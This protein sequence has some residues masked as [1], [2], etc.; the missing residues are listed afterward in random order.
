M[1]KWLALACMCLALPATAQTTLDLDQA[2][3]RALNHDPRIDEKRHYVAA[4]RGLLEEV[5]GHGGWF[6]ES[7][8]FLGL[9]PQV[10]GSIFKNGACAPGNCEL[11]D[12][13]Y[14]FNGLSPWL[15]LE[16]QLIKPLNTFGKLENYSDA[17][18]ANI[19][20]K[21][22]DVQL[23]RNATVLD[24]KKAYY[25]YLAAR[26]S[27][28]LLEDV[29][30]RAQGAIDL[31][32]Q[33]LDEGKGEVK[34]SDLY[35]LQSGRAL[36]AKYQAQAAALE[37]VALGGLKVLVGIPQ[38]EALEL[39]DRRLRP[40][41]LPDKTMK[42]LQAQALKQRPEMTQL[43]DGLE[44]RRALL[45]ADKANGKPDL[46][47]GV[48]GGLSYTP[49]RNRLNN[50][51]IYDPLNE[52]ALTPLIGLRWNWSPGVDDGKI[53]AAEAQLNALIA[54]SSFARAGIPY[55]VAEQYYQVQGYHEAVQNLEDA[56]RS[57][58]R[59]MI[60][61]YTDFEAGLE[62]AEKIMTA[63]Q[64]Y[65]LAMTD[66]VQTTFEYNMHVARLQD[67]AGMTQ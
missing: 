17:A 7:N 31:V 27:R 10:E 6:V 67:A 53:S 15:K 41:P 40:V 21:D 56:G 24:V 5:Q 45:A 54:K 28:L 33:W 26:D 43:K 9:A 52:A 64:A 35:A 12:D 50:P 19:R 25:G 48:A 44:A 47:A 61:S 30:K 8:T 18:E 1:R 39:A 46:Y 23:Q 49:G 29:G 51:Y 63:M 62:K 55:Q 16:A 59:W 2:I 14:K 66:Y 38:E 34:Q 11:R 60:A 13:R 42:D 4:A 22:Q 65:I 58:R 20:I 36:V 32:K 57:A 3:E 37:K